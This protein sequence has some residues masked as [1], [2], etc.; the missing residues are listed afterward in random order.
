MHP[1]TLV[2][3]DY[4]LYCDVV[5]WSQFYE[6]NWLTWTCS[7]GT[8][9]FLVTCYGP[10]TWYS[11][12]R[13]SW[14]VANPDTGPNHLSGSAR[15]GTWRNLQWN[16]FAPTSIYWNMKTRVL[17][18]VLEFLYNYDHMEGLESYWCSFLLVTSFVI[19]IFR[20]INP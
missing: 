6:H 7:S 5:Y 16:P 19:V 18:H 1:T 12:A 17:K 11:P 2:W 14:V 3:I 13:G 8:V 15:L 9:L 4:S 20:C 10:R